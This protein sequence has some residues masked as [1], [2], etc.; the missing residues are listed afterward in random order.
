MIQTTAMLLQN[1][2]YHGTGL[3]QILEQARAPK[4][5]LYFHFPGGKDELA[6]EALL[7]AG[8]AVDARLA[9]HEK[10]TVQESLESYL[11]SVAHQFEK[12]GFLTG[13]PI[14]TTALELAHS[15]ETVADAAKQAFETILNRVQRWF[16]KDGFA[17]KDA[18]E[19]AELVYSSI[20]GSLAI[21]KARRSR[22][23]LDALAK[24][25]D[26]FMKP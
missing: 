3:N 7:F 19:R 18:A 6:A 10:A 24:N 14:S 17:P 12:S 2:G 9:R 5:S 16:E 4:G 21:A 25:I 20:A 23:P 8:E 26:L 13:C 11:G 15:N 22:A 1:Q